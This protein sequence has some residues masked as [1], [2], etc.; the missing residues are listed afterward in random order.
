MP[1]PI[2]LFAFNRPQQLQ[3]VLK[4]LANN[5][6]AIES[7]ITI[8][9]DGPR[10]V[11]E[12]A[13][14]DTVRRTAYTSTGFNSV[15]VVERTH[16]LGCAQSIISGLQQMFAVHERLIVIEDDIITSPYTLQFLN[17]CL[18]KYHN[19]PVVF[20]IAAWSPPSLVHHM[21]DF[22]YDAFF[23]PRFSCWGWA[24]WRDR[25][26]KIDWAVS[27]YQLFCDTPTLQKAFNR[28]GHDLSPMLIAQMAG[29]LNTWDIMVDYALFKHGGLQLAPFQAYTSNI[30]MG[31][32]THC[33]QFTTKYDRD[34][35][36][37]LA[38]PI[39]PDHIFSDEKIIRTY[40]NFYAPA[41][42]PLRA[43]NKLCRLLFGRNLVDR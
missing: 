26:E 8:F 24:M 13:L 28:S 12:Q 5:L 10:T 27:D 37:A 14:T 6:L 30:G 34:T 7:D 21:V 39:L 32:G 29:V 22:P 31:S 3:S 15:T 17:T 33:T 38:E 40:R 20:S 25:F 19:E 23:A 9:C 41:P 16:N 18:T 42:L 11:Q 1:A 43:L 35:A 4:A 36:L 2:A